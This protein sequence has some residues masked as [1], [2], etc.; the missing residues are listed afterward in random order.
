MASVCFAP[1]PSGLLYAAA[2]TAVHCIDARMAGTAC[3]LPCSSGGEEL[4]SIG[5][6]AKGQYLA[7]AND[8]GEVQVSQHDGGL[9]HAR[10]RPLKPCVRAS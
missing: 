1:G 6:H 7:A 8:A 3:T 4:N 10:T 9:A 2:G 5:V